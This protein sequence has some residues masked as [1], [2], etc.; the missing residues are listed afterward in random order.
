MSLA[1]VQFTIFQFNIF[2][3]LE[4]QCRRSTKKLK[5]K[6]K[7]KTKKTKKKK[8]KKKK[9]TIPLLHKM[10]ILDCCAGAPTIR[11][12]LH[13]FNALTELNQKKKKD[14]SCTEIL[15]IHYSFISAVFSA[16]Y[17]FFGTPEF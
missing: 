16:C 15:N 7:P 11:V 5:L 9:N 1:E 8:K 14:R 6:K 13:K 17:K 10:N 3:L 12:C 4:I 2:L